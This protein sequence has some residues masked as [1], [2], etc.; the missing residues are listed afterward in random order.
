M[1]AFAQ[2]VQNAKWIW[3]DQQGYGGHAELTANS[4]REVAKTGEFDIFAPLPA[5]NPVRCSQR[6][7]EIAAVHKAKLKQGQILTRRL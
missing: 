3:N 5:G 6:L 2:S 7:I 4:A 1:I